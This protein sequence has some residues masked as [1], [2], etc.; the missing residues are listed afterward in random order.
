MTGMK[1]NFNREFTRKN[2]FQDINKFLNIKYKWGGKHYS[3]IDCSGLVQL[4]LNFNNQFCKFLIIP[5]D[6]PE[7]EEFDLIINLY[8]NNLD[9]IAQ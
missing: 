3:G 7:G 1:L 8:L 2:T 5:F 4:C 9:K 6:Q